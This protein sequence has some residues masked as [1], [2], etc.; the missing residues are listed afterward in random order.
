MTTKGSC[1]KLI[2]SES[3]ICK[4]KRMTLI[5]PSKDEFLLFLYYTSAG[6]HQ[7][8]S[9]NFRSP[10]QLGKRYQLFLRGARRLNNG[11]DVLNIKS[12]WWWFQQSWKMFMIGLIVLTGSSGLSNRQIRCILYPLEQQLDWHIWCGRMLQR[13]A[14][15]AH[16]L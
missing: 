4:V 11:Y 1:Q 15:I 9:A 8:R 12:T 2:K 16:G 5:T 7:F 10:C 3:S 6:L 13:L 14:S